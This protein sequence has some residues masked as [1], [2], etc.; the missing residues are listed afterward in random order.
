MSQQ[1]AA[2]VS[3]RDLGLS[4]TEREIFLAIRNQ[5][6]ISRVEISRLLSLSKGA[7]SKGLAK[8]SEA[9]IVD[10]ERELP[11]PRHSGQPAIRIKLRKDAV[12][13]VGLNLSTRGAYAAVSNLGSD[14]VWK[15]PF[16]PLEKSTSSIV[17]QA[18]NLVKSAQA[19]AGGI[20]IG[21]FV[22]AIFSASDEIL[23][24]TPKQSSVPF[25]E[26]KQGLIKQFPDSMVVASSRA[27][28]MYSALQPDLAGNVLFLIGFA[29][30]VAGH[31]FDRD[32]IVRGGYNQAGNIGGLIPET[33][34][35][36]SITD[37]AKTLNINPLTLA[38]ADIEALF[39][40]KNRALMDWIEDRGRGLSKPL[41][42]VVQLINPQKIVLGGNLPASVLEALKN[43]V[44][45]DEY[46]V[47]GR[48]RLSKPDIV[49]SN[50]IGESERAIAAA[51]LPLAKYVGYLD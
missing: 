29:D 10:E 35:R 20:D 1:Q 27:D 34:P 43:L 48:M 37:L 7:V 24:V 31:I 2:I 50:I 11:A 36:P 8:L 32:R 4:G 17:S 13:M 18:I 33:G 41:S 40:Q 51:S 49:I 23:E 12:R 16:H 46:D 19:A 42:A 15:S 38:T 5:S 28:I 25:E 22:P 3:L 30:G 9:G 21:V 47:P 44:D 6:G 45:L 14:K 26:V 39:L